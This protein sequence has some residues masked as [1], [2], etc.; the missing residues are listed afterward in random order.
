MIDSRF[1]L[2]APRS[3]KGKL[4][5]YPPSVKGVITNELFGYFLKIMTT[6]QEEIED[7]YIEKG[8][9]G[10]F[11]TPYEY[12]LNNCKENQ[13][14]ELLTKEAFKFFCHTEITFLYD[15]KMILIGNV[16]E[17]LKQGKELSDFVFLLE[18]DFFDFQNLIRVSVGDNKVEIP[19][20]DEDPRIKRIKAKARYRDKIKAKQGSGIS[21]AAS[22]TSIC[23]MGLGITPLNVGEMS[24]VAFKAIMSMYQ[25]KEKYD[26]DVKSLLAG[27]DSKKIK[28]KYWIKNF[29]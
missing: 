8:I 13:T 29:D 14:Y 4:Y 19:N 1:F 11:P 2:S 25:D 12:L 15:S 9:D 5:V 26:L 21:M 17:L 24:Y 20:P 18:E 28:P 16:E 6:S 7:E 27:A 22:L 23:C 10:I 3:Y